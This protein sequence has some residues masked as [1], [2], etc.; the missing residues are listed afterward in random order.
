MHQY[1]ICVSVTCLDLRGG[2]V[3]WISSRLLDQA[4]SKR[5]FVKIREVAFK[6]VYRFEVQV[7]LGAD[8]PAIPKYLRSS[9]KHIKQTLQASK[10][11][12]G[13]FTINYAYNIKHV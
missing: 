7:D 4:M 3:H 5:R 9:Y 2:W 1:S 13:D 10:V 11:N 12:Y 8:S 6:I